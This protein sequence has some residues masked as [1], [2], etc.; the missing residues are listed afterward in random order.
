MGKEDIFER[1]TL[2]RRESLVGLKLAAAKKSGEPSAMAAHKAW[3]ERM[4]KDFPDELIEI[5]T[6]IEETFIRVGK[7]RDDLKAGIKIEEKDII[8]LEGV[9]R[10]VQHV[11]LS[12]Q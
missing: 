8:F 7:L 10:D 1:A 5:A 11:D 2:I 3:L 4:A 12:E 6:N 9:I